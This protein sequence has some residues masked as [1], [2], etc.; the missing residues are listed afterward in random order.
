VAVR[1]PN[2]FK[3]DW[4]RAQYAH[5]LEAA[6]SEVAGGPVKLELSVAPAARRS[7]GHAPAP[8]A[9][10]AAATLALDALGVDGRGPAPGRHR[11]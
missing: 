9:P 11:R 5:R 4:I 2:R 7:P 6:L 1:V 10:T 3:L 8:H